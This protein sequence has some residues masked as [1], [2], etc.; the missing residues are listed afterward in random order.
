MPM[1]TVQKSYPFIPFPLHLK[2]TVFLQ[3]MSADIMTL[4]VFIKN[5]FMPPQCSVQAMLLSTALLQSKKEGVNVCQENVVRFRSESVDFLKRMRD[6]LGSD[7]H[8]VFDI[9]QSI[10]CGYDPFFVAEEFKNEI[11]HIHISDNSPQAD[12][13]PPGKGTFDFKRLFS[14]MADSNYQGGY[15]IEIYSKGYD[16]AKELEESKRFFDKI[17]L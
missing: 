4:S 12:C 15:V 6:Y 10:R 17:E 8:M 13:M 14:L 3:N 11:S 16:V 9:K 7:F 5:I 2:A 1:I